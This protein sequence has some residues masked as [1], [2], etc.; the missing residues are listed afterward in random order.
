VQ[1]KVLFELQAVDKDISSFEREMQEKPKEISLLQEEIQDQR[2]LLERK[3]I[4]KK[5]L[6]KARKDKEISLEDLEKRVAND[7]YK[8]LEVK[9]NKE[10][11][12]LQ[13]E[14]DTIKEN[15]GTIEEEI[16]L[17]MD[18]IE[19][20]DV[21]LKRTHTRVA[22][23]IE[24][25]EKKIAVHEGRLVEIPKLLEEKNTEK[26]E[27]KKG[28]DS[29]LLQRYES[30]KSQRGGLGVV[31]VENG[32]CMG[33]RL[34]IPPQQYNLILKNEDIYTCP[35]CHRILFYAGEAK[36]NEIK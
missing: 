28:I 23:H 22:K 33:C 2:D 15:M 7:N 24:E 4:G 20:Y 35:N 29:D 3:E 10:Y 19:Q 11:H 36:V 9:S 31:Q 26:G 18:E 8:L 25:L 1:L 30:T 5:N 21:D 17:L 34:E 13:K 16:L 32:I 14:I 12:A 27:L 6:I